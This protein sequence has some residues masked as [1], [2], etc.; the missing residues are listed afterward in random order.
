MATGGWPLGSGGL[1]R[2]VPLQRP[3]LEIR[4]TTVTQFT[5]QVDAVNRDVTVA[6]P[7]R[8][9]GEL[10]MGHESGGCSKNH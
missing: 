8:L 6:V 1:N 9:L 5:R 3:G 2:G 10:D 7:M 4:P